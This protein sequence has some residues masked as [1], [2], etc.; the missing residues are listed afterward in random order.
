ME[1]PKCHH[2]QSDNGTE[3]VSCGL[4]FA[5][6]RERPPEAA[7][8]PAPEQGRMSR[9]LEY[10]LFSRPSTTEAAVYGRAALLLF[11]FAWSWWFWL[12]SAD[13]GYA[14]R[15]FMHLVNLPFHEAGHVFTRPL[16]S[17]MT[18]LGGSLGQLLMPAVCLS[19]LLF[20]TRDTFGAAVSLWWLGESF[21]DLSPYI[22]DA[23]SMTLPL[24][25][26]NTGRSAP[27]GFHDWNYILSEAGLLEHD[28]LLA[29]LARLAGTA[30]MV[31]ALVWGGTVLLRAWRTERGS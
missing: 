20:R 14:G 29:G 3:C 2:P 17:F 12:D 19:V 23:G 22:G 4:I 30:F 28:Q 31:L 9:I 25:G 5:K 7:V 16:S 15:S 13:G 8:P 18:S 10:L 21:L 1:C 26:G 11:L 6:Y 27:Y 24:I